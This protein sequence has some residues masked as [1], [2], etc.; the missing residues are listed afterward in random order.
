MMLFESIEY[1]TKNTRLPDTEYFEIRVRK[2]A[3]GIFATTTKKLAYFGGDR[4]FLSRE[5]RNTIAKHDVVR[6]YQVEN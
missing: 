1:K 2:L 6:I 3:A 5:Y 4:K